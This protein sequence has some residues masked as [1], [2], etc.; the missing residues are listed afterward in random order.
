MARYNHF[1]VHKYKQVLF[2]ELAI[3][4]KFRN[5]FNRNGRSSLVVCIKTGELEYQE[6]KSGKVHK[7][8]FIPQDH[9]V[10]SYNILLTNH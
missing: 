7:M 8:L 1:G 5:Y 6:Q 4:D 3:G 2:S 9:Y 10:S